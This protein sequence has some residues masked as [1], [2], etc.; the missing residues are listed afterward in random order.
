KQYEF[1]AA[2]S[3]MKGRPSFDFDSGSARV[4]VTQLAGVLSARRLF[5]PE[6]GL[7]LHALGASAWGARAHSRNDLS[8]RTVLEDYANYTRVL[9]DPRRISTGRLYGASVDLQYAP[10][11]SLVLSS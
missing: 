2:V 7:G 11:S 8:S 6:S 9:Y 10:S 3:L 4:P 1:D 5:T